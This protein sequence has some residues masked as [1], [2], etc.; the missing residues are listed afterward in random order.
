MH[1]DDSAKR[2]NFLMCFSC[3]F[4]ALSNESAECTISTP[5]ICQKLCR[6]SHILSLL[7]LEQV[8]TENSEKKIVDVVSRLVPVA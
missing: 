4:P 3:N 1:D 2:K 8:R 7:D 6:D 5:L